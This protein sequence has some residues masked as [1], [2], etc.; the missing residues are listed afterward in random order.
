[1]V[2]KKTKRTYPKSKDKLKKF[3]DYLGYFGIAI[4]VLGIILLL[5]KIIGVF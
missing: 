2:K 1:M 4:G 5:L 3:F